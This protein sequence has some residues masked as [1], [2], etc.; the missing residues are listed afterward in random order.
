MM[1]AEVAVCWGFSKGGLRTSRIADVWTA[2]NE[3]MAVTTM[4]AVSAKSGSRLGKRSANIVLPAP[5]GPV[6]NMWWP[7]AAAT[8]KARHASPCPD[9]SQRSG[10]NRAA[11]RAQ[12]T[13]ELDQHNRAAANLAR[14]SAQAHAE[15]LLTDIDSACPSLF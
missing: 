5:G 12:G 1:V 14:R 2:A 13:K 15:L 8:S 10:T 11:S 3:W 4:A 6:R 7:P 9:T